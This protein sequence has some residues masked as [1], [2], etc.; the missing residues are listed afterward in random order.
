MIGDIYRASTGVFYIDMSNPKGPERITIGVY[1]HRKLKP[2]TINFL[3][4]SSI[5]DFA[6]KD[7]VLIGNICTIL[8]NS[9]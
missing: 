6:G 3:S 8:G 1:I 7:S 4:P 2:P 5:T 9:E